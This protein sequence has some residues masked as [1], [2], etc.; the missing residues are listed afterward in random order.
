MGHEAGQ[1]RRL[2]PPSANPWFLPC[3]SSWPAGEGGGRGQLLT[4]YIHGALLSRAQVALFLRHDNV[5]DVLHG[6]VLTEGVVEQPLQL[7]HSQLLH[8]TLGWEE[9]VLWTPQSPPSACSHTSQ[10]Q[11]S[12]FWEAGN[13]SPFLKSLTNTSLPQGAHDPLGDKMPSGQKAEVVIPP[14]QNGPGHSLVSVWPFT[15][16]TAL[17]PSQ[18]TAYL[19]EDS[20][21][22]SAKEPLWDP[23]GGELGSQEGHKLL[24]VHLAIT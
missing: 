2:Q 6:Q 23:R 5:L 7:I 10:G 19:P 20:V 17:G 13:H 16:Y 15:V 8:V 4:L 14:L 3:S 21:K 9:T 11:A 22:V 1:A 12:R 18:Y 24:K